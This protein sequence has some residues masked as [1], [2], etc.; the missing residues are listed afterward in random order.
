MTR[1]IVLGAGSVGATIAAMLT[2]SGDYEVTA[3][4]RNAAFLNAISDARI[5]KRQIDVGDAQAVAQEIA[6][7][8]I[9]ASALPYFLNRSVAQAARAAARI[10][11]I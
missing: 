2:E 3:A 6:G 9:V 11:S 8:A 4:D 5:A 7:H 10:T 1:V